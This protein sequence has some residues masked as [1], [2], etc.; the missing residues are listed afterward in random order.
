MKYYENMALEATEYKYSFIKRISTPTQKANIIPRAMHFVIAVLL[1]SGASAQCNPGQSSADGRTNC[2]EC[3]VGTYQGLIGQTLC[4][5]CPLGMFSNAT[6]ATSC[7]SCPEGTFSSSEGASEC[8]LC[9]L[10]KYQNSTGAIS[11]TGAA[12]LCVRN[13]ASFAAWRE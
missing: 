5:N 10:G 6:G 9:P 12:Y 4:L 3:H 1:L 2:T 8:E 13:C 11:C 7:T